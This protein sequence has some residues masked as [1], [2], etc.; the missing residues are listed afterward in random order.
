VRFGGDQ[1][2]DGVCQC[3]ERCDVE[4]GKRVFAFEHASRGQDDGDKVDAGIAEEEERRGLGEE[5]D[6]D[7]GDIADDV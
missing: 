7:D 2:G 3:R 6:V 1:F 5:F 4:D